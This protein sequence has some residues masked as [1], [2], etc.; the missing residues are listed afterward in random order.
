MVSATALAVASRYSVE[1]FKKAFSEFG[2]S[3][4]SVGGKK[5]Q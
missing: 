3:V 1:G 5:D 4:S 2:D